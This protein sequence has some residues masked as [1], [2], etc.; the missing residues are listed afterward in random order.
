[1]ELSKEYWK[2]KQQNRIPRMKWRVLRKCHTYNQKKRAYLMG[3]V[4]KKVPFLAKA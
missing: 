1:M 4:Q 2:V 3:H